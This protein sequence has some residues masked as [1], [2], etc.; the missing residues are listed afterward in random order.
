MITSAQEGRFSAAIRALVVVVTL[1]VLVA[2]G[3]PLLALVPL[4]ML[5]ALWALL[6]VPPHR[7]GLFVFFLA[8]VTDNPKEH[9]AL[10]RWTSPLKPI[11]VALYE[12]LNNL[13]GIGPLRFSGMDL[14]LTLL[15]LLVVARERRRETVAPPPVLHTFLIVAW[16]GILWLE[17]WG[18]ARGGDFK[19]S[20]WQARPLF[21]TP[22][23]VYILSALMR[24]PED[25]LAI[26]KAIIVAAMIKAAFGVY[27][28]MVICRPIGFVPSYSTTH[29]DTV[30]FV[31]AVV[32]ALAMWLEKRTTPVLLLSLAIIFVV[33]LGIVVNGRRLAYI[34]IA[35]VILA[36]R[37][38]LPPD[39]LRRTFDRVL[40]WG[41]PVGIVYLAVGWTSSAS[42]FIP[43][44]KVASLFAKDDSSSMMRDIENY[45]LIMTWREQLLLGSGFGHEYREVTHPIG[46]DHIFAMYRFI[47]HNSILWLQAAG[48]VVGF[49]AFWMLL[50][51][52]AYFAARSHR[53]AQRPEDRAAALT[54]LSVVTIYGVQAHGDMGL[55]SW[56]AVFFLAMS[57]TVAAK[58]AR[59][60]GAYSDR[61]RLVQQGRAPLL[62]EGA[63]PCSLSTSS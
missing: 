48:G 45:N 50:A 42:I 43:A 62:A 2:L 39:G 41:T 32:V 60:T 8:I 35:G 12:N 29:S 11:G 46:I 20:L 58:L 23:I 5:V 24:G 59:A 18:M 15:L 34:A 17:V 47:G 26:G 27:F 1:I 9:P 61:P 25:H 19:A 21:W 54:A 31:T 10:D 30:L 16:L 57:L 63:E 53:F 22:V 52:V 6:S 33:G 38:V 13:T 36:L 37:F 44:R 55:N 40:L 51:A 7:L 56:T 4:L 3:D 28:Y 49:T 14:L